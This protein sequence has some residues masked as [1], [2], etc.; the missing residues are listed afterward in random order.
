[1]FID[2]EKAFDRV[3]H[4][5][6]LKTIKQFNFGPAFISW[7]ET[8]LTDI[9]SQVKVNGYLTEEIN[10]TRG[11]I[12]GSPISALLY[13]L[14]AEVLGAAIRKNEKIQG[15]KILNSE[16]K[17]LQYADDTEN[18]ATTDESINEIF[19]IIDKYEK[20]TGAKINVEKT[21]G[22]IFG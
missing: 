18:F 20:G 10:V 1:M 8:I 5:F 14:I 12:Q 21:E 7:I 4:R 19:Y 15:V 13:V 17:V 6:L 2:Q 3:S 11:I 22:L 16:L 9:K